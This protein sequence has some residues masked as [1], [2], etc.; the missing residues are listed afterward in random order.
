MDFE[1][2]TTEKRNSASENIDKVSTLEM[3]KIINDEDK[4]VAFA[5][6]KVLPEIATAVDL[7]SEKLSCGGRLFYIGA[8]TSGR[9]GV[10]DA[11]EIP[12]TFGTS[13]ELVQGII[14]GG[15]DALISAVEGAE[16]NFDS[17]AE[18]LTEKNFSEKDI[19]VGIASSGRTPFVLGGIN[20]AKKIGAMTVGISCVE[21]SELKK[22][23]DIAITPITGAEIVSGSTRLK[24]GTATKMILNMLTTG[25][26]I[27]L[28]KVYGNL[29]VDVRAT[30][31]KLR[32]RAKRIVQA[33]A[34]CSEVDAE[35]ALKKNNFHA[36]AAIDF[37]IGKKLM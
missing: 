14:A 27:R 21:N 37:L 15:N 16:D 17:A 9:L 8:G 29:M 18:I 12:P 3:V 34:N 10:L 36:K 33:V 24:A 35:N 28:G 4:K 19:L 1:N 30:N 23:S 31:E 2:L 32:D 20:F 5:V 7:I 22:I 26:M 13:P 25:A 11:S 6:E